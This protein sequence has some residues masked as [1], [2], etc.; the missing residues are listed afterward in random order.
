MSFA[1]DVEDRK[2]Y[3]RA[4]GEFMTS[5]D[6]F[7]KFRFE[8]PVTRQEASKFL[9]LWAEALDLEVGSDQKCSFQDLDNANP[10]LVPTIYEW[11]RDGIFKAQANFMPFDSLTRAQAE[12]TIVRLLKWFDEVNRYASEH[13]LGE[14][15]AAREILTNEGVIGRGWTIDPNSS[16][17][18]GHLLLMLYRLP[19]AGIS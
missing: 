18:R 4:L 1:D 19:E 15:A 11:C 12:L 6:S 17:R 9:V 7:Q 14:F 13:S 8:D 2:A 3:E 16:V 5:M 10:S